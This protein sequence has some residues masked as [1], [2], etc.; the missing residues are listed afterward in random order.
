VIGALVALAAVV[1]LVAFGS[2]LVCAPMLRDIAAH[3]PPDFEPR[4]RGLQMRNRALAPLPIV[5][6]FAAMTVGA[7]V[8]AVH[9]RHLRISFALGVCTVTVAVATFIF[10]IVSRSVL[11]PIDELLAATERVRRGDISTPVP[12]TSADELGR[13]SSAFN[14][15]LR[16]LRQRTDELRA[17]RERIVA[18]GDAERRRVERDLHDGAQQQLVL[19]QLKL[20]TLERLVTAT[21]TAAALASELR[22]DLDR[23]LS[24]LRDL[25]QGL[26]PPLLETEGL[27]AALSEAARRSA[28]TASVDCD[29]VDRYRPELEAAVYFCCL[30]ALQNV[31]KHAGNG[32]RATVRLTDHRDRL[33]F[34]VA[35]DGRGFE[36]AGASV[37]SGLQNIT[38]RIGAL[39]GI[40]SIGSAPGAGTTI[41]GT[42]PLDSGGGESWS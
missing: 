42:I 41:V 35:D 2:E 36:P 30:E 31:A 33:R 34:E 4:A 37:N 23:A 26:Y 1:I 39:G 21:P 15:M 18:A 22:G 19:A 20:G 17:S 29:G 6:F 13:L 27:P 8:D 7:Y 11:S 10:A 12:L 28:I 14:G 16:D 24:E 38:D 40:V 5:T 25:A 3:L 9:D 32:A